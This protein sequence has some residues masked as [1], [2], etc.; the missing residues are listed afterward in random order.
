MLRIMI[1]DSPPSGSRLS[2]DGHNLSPVGRSTRA[3]IRALAAEGIEANLGAQ[4]LSSLGLYGPQAGLSVGP[5]LQRRG[6][7]I[8]LHES[9][10]DGDVARVCRALE[11]VLQ[12]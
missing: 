2:G 4:S 6:L 1:P 9:L 11:T 3:V 5:D 8:P 12:A 10:S 7:A